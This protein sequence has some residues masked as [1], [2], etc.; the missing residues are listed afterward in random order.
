MQRIGFGAQPYLVYK[1]SLADAHAQAVAM[2]R[3]LALAAT[4][5]LD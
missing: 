3:L 1:W 2:D 4:T 5:P